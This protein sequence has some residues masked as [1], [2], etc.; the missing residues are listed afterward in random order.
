MQPHL[1]CPAHLEQTMYH[2]FTTSNNGQSDKGILI[3]KGE[4]DP[5]SSKVQNI[6]TQSAYNWDV[7]QD[8]ISKLCN[9]IYAMKSQMQVTLIENK[10]LR[11]EI[12]EMKSHTQA[13]V[14]KNLGSRQEIRI[15]ATAIHMDWD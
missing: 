14:I 10:Q 15:R 6:F 4:V 1:R 9:K 12:H 2:S 11:K 5:L 8:S 13:A 7:T 3:M